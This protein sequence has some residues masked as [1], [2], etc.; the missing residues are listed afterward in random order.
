[1][2]GTHRMRTNNLHLRRLEGRDA[3]VV[4]EYF[5]AFL[6]D[7]RYKYVYIYNSVDIS[8]QHNHNQISHHLVRRQKE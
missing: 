4:R 7:V 8:A 1:M 6:N 3:H 2:S 5:L